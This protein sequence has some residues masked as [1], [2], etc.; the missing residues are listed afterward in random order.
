[1]PL[2]ACLV[3]NLAADC[4]SSI[5][6]R[7]WLICSLLRWSASSSFFPSVSPRSTMKAI[8]ATKA[9]E[10][11]AAYY[12]ERAHFY[13]GEVNYLRWRSA[14]ENSNVAVTRDIDL[15]IGKDRANL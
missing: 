4:G 5:R 2:A 12:S 13:P 11:G 8:H 3:R 9:C 15:R 14:Q 1:M 10:G 7:S 6:S